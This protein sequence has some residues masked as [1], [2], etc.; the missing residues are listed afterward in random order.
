ME[1]ENYQNLLTVVQLGSEVS[2]PLRGV[3]LGGLVV[4]YDLLL[5]LDSLLQLLA[6]GPV[7]GGLL[8]SHGSGV[9]SEAGG[10][11]HPRLG[12]HIKRTLCD[13][14]TIDSA[15]SQQL[16]VGVFYFLT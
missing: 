6:P 12:H 10:H 1:C 2:H 16:V 11:D 3:D 5:G 8:L 14:T 9:I 4:G 15:K 7:E 13:A